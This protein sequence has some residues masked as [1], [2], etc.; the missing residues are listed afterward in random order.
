MSTARRVI[1][2]KALVG[3]FLV[4]PLSGPASFPKVGRSRPWDIEGR[5]IERRSPSGQVLARLRLRPGTSPGEFTFE[6]EDFKHVARAFG[7]GKISGRTA[8]VHLVESRSQTKIGMRALAWG[9]EGEVRITLSLDRLD[10]NFILDKKVLSLME[11]LQR[12]GARG[13]NDARR[14]LL[15]A[16]VDKALYISSRYRPFIEQVRNS[17]AFNVVA[18]VRS[19][20]STVPSEEVRQ[21]PALVVL[22]YTVGLF[23]PSIRSG[24]SVSWRKVTDGQWANLRGTSLRQLSLGISPTLSFPQTNPPPQT[25]PACLQIYQDCMNIFYCGGHGQPLDALCWLMC[26]AFYVMCELLF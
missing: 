6:V 24:T 15:V 22:Q 9:T 14:R 3:V 2:M 11:E 26:V 23:D 8:E 20:I 4:V 17:S 13:V 7:A 21:N 19:L 1:Q 5:V 25:D 10:F 18:T 16:E 12:L